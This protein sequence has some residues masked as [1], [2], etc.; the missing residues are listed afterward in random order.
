M[1]G[2]GTATVARARAARATT[3][4][5]GVKTSG[6]VKC[7]S[8]GNPIYAAINGVVTF[9]LGILIFTDWPISGLWIIGFFI[10]IDM[11]LSGWSWLLLTLFSRNYIK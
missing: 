6:A 5:A 3:D 7:G 1:E 2:A 10:G 4:C 9:L 11:I 8:G